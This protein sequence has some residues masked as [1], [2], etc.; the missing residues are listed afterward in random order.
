MQQTVLPE[1]SSNSS[2]DLE[3]VSISPS[4][5][6]EDEKDSDSSSENETPMLTE[7]QDAVTQSIQKDLVLVRCPPNKQDP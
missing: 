2:K 3:H 7:P 5:S 4:D 1:R 6:D